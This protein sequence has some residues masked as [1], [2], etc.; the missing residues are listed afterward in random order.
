LVFHPVHPVNPVQKFRFQAC[1]RHAIEQSEQAR[2]ATNSNQSGPR[3]RRGRETA[4]GSKLRL[5]ACAASGRTH[6]DATSRCFQAPLGHAAPPISVA[7]KS[8]DQGFKFCRRSSITTITV[9]IF[10]VIQRRERLYRNNN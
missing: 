3:V 2:L 10:A 7:K 4:I 8:L 5:V 1:H 6:L 9:K